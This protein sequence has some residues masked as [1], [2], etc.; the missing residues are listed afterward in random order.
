MMPLP[1]QLSLNLEQIKVLV[2][3]MH[4]VAVCD[5]ISDAEQVLLRE[6][7]EGCRHDL[8]GAS[9]YEDI[10]SEPLNMDAAKLALKTPELRDLFL[11]SCILTAFVDGKLTDAERAIFAEYCKALDVSEDHFA[12]LQEKTR[13]YLVRSIVT[14]VQS[15]DSLVALSRALM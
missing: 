12:D 1:T 15:H 4:A 9:S 11:Q 13:S 10:I 7:Y 3:G 2:R 14:D 6:F 5:G 8:A